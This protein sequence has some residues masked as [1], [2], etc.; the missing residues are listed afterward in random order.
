[1]SPGCKSHDTRPSVAL[2]PYFTYV[3]RIKYGHQMFTESLWDGL[4]Q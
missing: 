2:E 3:G 4:L 1:M